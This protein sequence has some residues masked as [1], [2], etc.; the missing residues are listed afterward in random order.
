MI[1]TFL[2]ILSFEVMH[3]P[4]TTCLYSANLL[5]ILF[6]Y[7]ILYI[8]WTLISLSWLFSLGPL[9]C[10]QFFSETTKIYT[11]LLSL[12]YSQLPL[13]ISSSPHCSTE[14]SQIITHVLRDQLLT[15]WMP[16][17]DR[18]RLTRQRD[19]LKAVLLLSHLGYSL[20]LDWELRKY[21]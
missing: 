10:L 1:L 13:L 6:L 16:I 20:P 11:M 8:L 3:L 7:I 9:Y 12:G 19:S 17:H 18:S 15:D 4:S 14:A 5:F 21:P 2:W